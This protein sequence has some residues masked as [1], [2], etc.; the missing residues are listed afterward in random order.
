MLAPSVAAIFRRGWPFVHTAP[1][2]SGPRRGRKRPGRAINLLGSQEGRTVFTG[3]TQVTIDGGLICYFDHL[4]FRGDGSSI[5]LSASA[6]VHLTN[7]TISG[8]KTGVLAY[9]RT[10]INCM[11]CRFED[12]KVGLHFNATDDAVSH[13]IYS[14]NE[15]TNNGTA[16]LLES[17]P[18]DVSLKF[19]GSVFSGNGTDIDNRCAQDLDISQAVFH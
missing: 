6:R 19:P 15:F 8:W 4:D 7:C 14:D 3:N 1:A 12:N 17:V 11:N 2:A 9:G 5:G 18:T 16:V 10:W 13:T